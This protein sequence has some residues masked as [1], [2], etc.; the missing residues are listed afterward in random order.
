MSKHPSSSL[1]I[2]ALLAACVLLLPAGT[3][4]AGILDLSANATDQS[5]IHGGQPQFIGSN[6]FDNNGGT[7]WASDFPNTPQ[8]LWVDLG[9]LD[10]VLSSVTIDWETANATNYE[11]RTRTTSQGPTSNPA[12]WTL[13]ASVT[14]HAGLPGGGAPGVDDLLDFST[15]AVSLSPPGGAGTVNVQNPVGR[16]LMFHTTDYSTTCCDGASIW[17]VT[18]DANPIPEPGTLALAAWG[19]V[20]LGLLG[21]RRHR[22]AAKT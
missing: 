13:V 3:T 21:W 17:E 2:A 4:V 12:D 20:G 9:T 19:L 11:L 5:S 18:V 1:R 7:R 22:I 8:W 10:H 14:G 16:Y 15:G 6:A